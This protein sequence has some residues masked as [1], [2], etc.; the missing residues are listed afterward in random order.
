MFILT[1]IIE[2]LRNRKYAAMRGPCIHTYIRDLLSGN[3]ILW[4]FV[5]PAYIAADLYTGKLGRLVLWYVHGAYM[6]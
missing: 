1:N 6:C 3:C 4:L 5:P 2:L